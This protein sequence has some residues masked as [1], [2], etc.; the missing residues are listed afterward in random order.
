[1]KKL[2]P[3]LV[4]VVLSLLLCSCKAE[5][6]PLSEAVMLDNDKLTEADKQQAV[7]I[8]GEIAKRIERENNIETLLNAKGFNKCVAV[9]GD[10]NITVVVSSNGLTTAQTMQIQDVITSQTQIGLANIKIIPSK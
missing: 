10:D 7:K 1:M 4:P 8:A 9:M 6:I 3:A 2:K 5:I